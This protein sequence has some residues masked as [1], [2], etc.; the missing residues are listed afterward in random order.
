MLAVLH[1]EALPAM[2]TLS[3]YLSP[4]EWLKWWRGLP[5]EEVEPSSSLPVTRPNGEEA[6]RQSM[7]LHKEFVE[8]ASSKHSLQRS[9][10][11]RGEQIIPYPGMASPSAQTLHLKLFKRYAAGD[12]GLLMNDHLFVVSVERDGAAHIGGVLPLDRVVAVDGHPTSQETIGEQ[13]SARATILLTVERPPVQDLSRLARVQAVR[14]WTEFEK[15]V[16]SCVEGDMDA[17][18][19]AFEGLRSLESESRPTDRQITNQE[20]AAFWAIHKLEVEPGATMGTVASDHEQQAVLAFLLSELAQKPSSG[21]DKATGEEALHTELPAP[22]VSSLVSRRLEEL[23]GCERQPPSS[24]LR[25]PTLRWSGGTRSS[26]ADSHDSGSE[27][28]R[29]SSC[30][31]RESVPDAFELEARDDQVRNSMLVREGEPEREPSRSI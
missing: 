30:E 21:G 31:S 22:V 23:S 8:T 15:A 14:E 19:E 9:A 26:G 25:A 6:R 20:A 5:S 1:A 3:S 7:D 29:S 17:L 18:L 11:A 12:F 4:R 13:V 24:P 16:L 10:N 27:R 2:E 28:G